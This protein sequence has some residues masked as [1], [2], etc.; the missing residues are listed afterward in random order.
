ML[1]PIVFPSPNRKHKATLTY[2]GEIGVDHD[3][4]S[5]SIDDFPHSFENRVFGR[6][7]M[8]SPDSRFLS[9]QEL[10][11]TNEIIQPKS[12]LLL[13]IDLIARRECVVASVDGSK[14][15]ILPEGFIGE[16]LM[17]TVIYEGQFGTTKN[18]ES[19]FQ[20]LDSW[21]TIK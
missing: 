13:I 14:S 17:Y 10:K 6:V 1:K 5:L 20:Y 7:C 15:S 3:Y 4:Y 16:S 11:E 8:W 2:L 19:K 18:F 21:Q 12:Y 9:V